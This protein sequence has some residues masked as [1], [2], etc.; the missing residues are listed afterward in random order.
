MLRAVSD[1]TSTIAIMY[2]N[3]DHIS[4]IL[5]GLRGFSKLQQATDQ[6]GSALKL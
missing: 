3:I 4:I 2:S 1:S 6:R 5:K